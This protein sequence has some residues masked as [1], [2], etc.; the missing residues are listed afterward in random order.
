MYT[1]GTTGRAKGVML[2]H[3]NLWNAGRSFQKASHVPGIVRGLTPL[4]LSH[5]YGLLITVVGLHTT[6]EQQGVL[7]RW[8]DPTG[9]LELAQQ[10][11]IRS[12]PSSRR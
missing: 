3:Y 8:F 2:S 11:A 4:S 7:M 1:G 12:R 5:S 10:H 6:E 9:W